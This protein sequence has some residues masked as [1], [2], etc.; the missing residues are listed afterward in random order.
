VGRI[1]NEWTWGPDGAPASVLDAFVE[2]KTLVLR[3]DGKP[4]TAPIT[5]RRNQWAESESI[6]LA[7][8]SIVLG[9]RERAYSIDSYVFRDGRSLVS[10]LTLEEAR[11]GLTRSA[12]AVT[13]E[14]EQTLRK[15]S[16]SYVSAPR[17]FLAR[18]ASAG[19]SADHLLGQYSGRGSDIGNRNDIAQ[20]GPIG[21]LGALA[22]LVVASLYCL[23]DARQDAFFVIPGV[24]AFLLALYLL[25]GLLVSYVAFIEEPRAQAGAGSAG[26]SGYPVSDANV[27]VSGLTTDLWGRTSAIREAHGQLKRP[28]Y[29]ATTGPFDIELI[30]HVAAKPIHLDPSAILEARAGAVFPW[31]GARP[32]V[33]M[34]TG[35]H[36]LLLSFDDPETRDAWLRYI[37]AM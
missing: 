32:A 13:P 24:A 3:S 33:R 14:R 16:P 29:S 17:A 18:L 35:Q 4:I 7:G 20:P 1:I 6:V 37:L 5:L 19:G 11:S 34:V 28:D 36:P 25:A 9:A 22:T 10:D 26:G 2:G 31:H 15:W 30:P 27:R 8:A 12:P 21:P 23:W